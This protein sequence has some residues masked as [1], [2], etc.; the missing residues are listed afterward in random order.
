MGVSE[1]VHQ[2]SVC[3]SRTTFLMKKKHDRRSPHP[4]RGRNPVTQ[5][6]EWPIFLAIVLCAA[7]LPAYFFQPVVS[8]NQGLGWDGVIYYQMVIQAFNG[9]EI[10]QRAPFAYRQLLPRLVALLV[11]EP[12]PAAVITVFKS[13][14]VSA[15]VLA[16]C[17]ILFLLRFFVADWRLRVAIAVLYPL[18]A[19]GYVRFTYL[20]PIQ[21]DA[22]TFLCLTAVLIGMHYSRTQPSQ[23]RWPLSVVFL[24]AVLTRPSTL[25]WSLAVFFCVVPGTKGSW[26]KRHVITRLRHQRLAFFLPFL[27]ALAGFFFVRHTVVVTGYFGEEQQYGS[28]WAFYLASAQQI[29][30]NWP[31]F[32]YGVFLAFGPAVIIVLW[33]WRAVWALLQTQR[34]WVFILGFQIGVAFMVEPQRMLLYAFPIY[35]VL[36]AVAIQHAGDALYRKKLL[37]TLLVIAQCISQRLF[38]TLPHQ[39][40]YPVP[41]MVPPDYPLQLPHLFTPFTND[42]LLY[43]IMLP[44]A[45][46]QFVHA[47]LLSYVLFSAVMLIWLIFPRNPSKR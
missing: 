32:L 22:I 14:N 30:A 39:I 8:L 7:V 28:L 16:S 34:H 1:S 41:E 21:T 12:S 43:D 10:A 13:L 5:T 45:R 33:Q 17:L 40:D 35:A 38:W 4:V 36:L 6:P 37:C 9:D 18:H 3:I 42:F 11:D 27:V 44:Y 15:A 24:L 31:I 19:Q 20:L 26:W 23:W 29:I 25:V 2:P 46:E 47:S